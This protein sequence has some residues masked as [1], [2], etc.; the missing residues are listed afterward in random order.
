MGGVWGCL[1]RDILNSLPLVRLTGPVQKPSSEQQ[2]SQMNLVADEAR[3]I[4]LGLKI[5][6]EDIH[7]YWNM[8]EG[9]LQDLL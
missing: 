7:P 2:L 6:L 5:C 4:G 8:L 3:G 1:R 9:P